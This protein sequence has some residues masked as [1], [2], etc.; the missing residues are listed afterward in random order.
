MHRSQERACVVCLSCSFPPIAP[1]RKKSKTDRGHEPSAFA[2]R[3]PA[4]FR[5]TSV[6]RKA[7]HKPP[8]VISDI[9]IQ[10]GIFVNCKYR[11]NLQVRRRPLCKTAQIPTFPGR[12]GRES[13]QKKRKPHIFNVIIFVRPVVFG[14][15][16][17]AAGYATSPPKPANPSGCAEKRSAYIFTVRRFLCL[18]IPFFA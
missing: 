6:V 17:T 12:S 2:S 15:R 16:G 18:N 13:R 8:P 5:K 14:A 9:I 7:F 11:Q 3:R 4:E 10:I 1:Q